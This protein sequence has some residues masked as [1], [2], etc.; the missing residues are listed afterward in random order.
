MRSKSMS[1]KKTALG[2][3]EGHGKN[4]CLHYWQ[5]ERGLMAVRALLAAFT[6]L[7]GLLDVATPRLAH[8]QTTPTAPYLDSRGWT[9]FTPTP[10]TSGTCAAGNANGTCIFYVSD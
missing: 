8:A 1:S 9:V 10:I 2:K 5:A 3:S 6:L 4:A 7:P